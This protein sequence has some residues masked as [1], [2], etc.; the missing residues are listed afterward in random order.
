[1]QVI[2]SVAENLLASEEALYSMELS[3]QIPDKY[4]RH[5]TSTSV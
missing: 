3:G 1:M 2:S 5:N 4:V